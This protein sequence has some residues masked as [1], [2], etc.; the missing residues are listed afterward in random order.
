MKK[1]LMVGFILSIGSIW[2]M[3]DQEK[4]A[5]QLGRVESLIMQTREQLPN[6]KYL[7]QQNQVQFFDTRIG[8]I[9]QLIQQIKGELSQDQLDVELVKSALSGLNEVAAD[10]HAR[11]MALPQIK[12]K[13]G[14]KTHGPRGRT[15][16]QP[17]GPKRTPPTRKP[18]PE[19]SR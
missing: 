13:P 16:S 5:Q 12:Y 7:S 4:I 17:T 11:K 8:D 1:M 2:S 19:C 14:Q 9:Q 6:I 18:S 3:N 15:V 10:L